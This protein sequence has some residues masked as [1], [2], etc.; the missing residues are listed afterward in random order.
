MHRRIPFTLWLYL[1]GDL[2]KLVLLTTGVLVT[3]IAFA[4]AVKPLADGKLS[5]EETLKFM[6]L[7][8]VPMLQYALPFAACFGATL[9]YHRL[10]TDNELTAVYAGGISHRAM[11]FPAVLSG[12][13]LG[14]ILLG[15]SDW[16]IPRFLRQMSGMITQDATKM[17]VSSIQRGEAMRME[18]KF[19]YAD[20]VEEDT[21]EPTDGYRKLWL[22][23]LLLVTLDDSEHVIN[24]FCARS[25]HVWLRRTT[26]TRPGGGEA[27][28]V[29][30]VI[31]QPIE[32]VGFGQTF[33]GDSGET[34]FVILVPDAFS[35]NVKF[36]S[37]NEL[38]ALRAE[39]SRID[40]VDKVKRALALEVARREM[41]DAIDRDLKTTGRAE[42]K[43][44]YDRAIT[45]R[46][47]GLRSTRR[48]GTHERDP[49]V[50]QVLPGLAD[51]GVV[52]E[53]TPPGAKMVRQPAA[54]AYIRLPAAPDPD[55]AAGGGARV[56][57]DLRRVAAEQVGP[58][59]EVVAPA[60]DVAPASGEVA[61]RSMADLAYIGDGSAAMMQRG[62]Y[63]VERLADQRMVVKPADKPVLA[64]AM[65]KLTSDVRDLLREILSK[66]HERYAMSAACLVMVLV[67]AVMAMRLREALPLTVY[68]WAFFP[69]LATVLAISGGQQLTHGKGLVGLPVLWAGV[70]C[71]GAFSVAEFV[72]LCKH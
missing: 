45:L 25:A 31:I 22:G 35:D 54:D 59:G 68:L 65:E 60:E 6:G 14:G 13:L 11:L 43:D 47:A 42:F 62:A 32:A 44:Y 21:R 8:M 46:A 66:E 9:A 52:V 67:G 17:I 50:F 36:L 23:G 64:P 61:V 10:A 16:V 38:R 53:M 70:A 40:R 2:W 55:R 24:E 37:F 20:L 69:A 5:Q 15:L 63:D 57:L 3:V 1:L 48:E 28:A 71:L 41:I 12:V 39:P 34:T 30:Q 29:T 33:R 56:T 18:N 72:R 51:R 7:A 19:L 49:N 26:V 58:D 4:A 27:K